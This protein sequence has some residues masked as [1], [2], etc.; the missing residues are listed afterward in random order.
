MRRNTD[1]WQ[2]KVFFTDL[3][4]LCRQWILLAEMLLLE[5]MKLEACF[6]YSPT[7]LCFVACCRREGFGSVTWRWL[8]GFLEV[9]TNLEVQRYNTSTTD[10]HQRQGL[11]RATWHRRLSAKI[12]AVC[13]WWPEVYLASV[14]RRRWR[15]ALVVKVFDVHVHA[16]ETF[17]DINSPAGD[18]IRDQ[19]TDA[20]GCRRGRTPTSSTAGL[21]ETRSRLRVTDR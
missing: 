13:C 1:H 2:V 12:P 18:V 9:L 3:C 14:G 17:L 6:L 19:W 16:T 10:R 21:H 7:W 11:E 5:V 20:V 15:K 8:R 4:W